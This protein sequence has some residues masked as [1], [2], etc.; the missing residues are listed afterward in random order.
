MFYDFLIQVYKETSEIN[1]I[2]QHL[3]SYVFDYE[4]QCDV[5]P[6][7]E[8]LLYKTFGKDV[9][10]TFTVFCD[11]DIKVGTIVKF[12]GKVYKINQKIDW[13]SYRIYSI[14]DSEVTLND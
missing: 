7:T 2:G 10:S 14:V 4:I 13:I 11:E 12:N 5:Q 8:Q 6:S 3:T 9:E 1:K